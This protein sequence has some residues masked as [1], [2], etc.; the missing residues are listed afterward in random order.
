MDKDTAIW[1]AVTLLVGVGI[2]MTGWVNVSIGYLC[3]L[4]AAILIVYQIS[5]L[6]KRK[7]SRAVNKKPIITEGPGKE[8]LQSEQNEAEMFISLQEVCRK[9]F[10][11]L[12]KEEAPLGYSIE[13]IQKELRIL[14]E[15]N[16]IGWNIAQETK[17]YGKRSVSA[18]MEL[19]DEDEFTISERIKQGASVLTW[20]E[21]YIKMEPRFIELSI[22][23]SDLDEAIIKAKARLKR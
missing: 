5:G 12:G 3:L 7:L 18:K 4:V 10:K 21:G 17:I 2:T 6:W 20:P 9:V 11:D 1:T 14:D 13:Y 8:Q 22:K 15:L 16:K 23:R 19:I